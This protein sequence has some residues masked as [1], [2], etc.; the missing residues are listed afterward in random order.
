MFS[1]FEKKVTELQIRYRFLTIVAIIFVLHC[2]V[3]LLRTKKSYWIDSLQIH[4]RFVTLVAN[5]FV[6]LQQIELINVST[7]TRTPETL[8]VMNNRLFNMFVKHLRVSAW[9]FT[10]S[11][12]MFVNLC[13]CSRGFV[14]NNTASVKR[15]QFQVCKDSMDFSLNRIEIQWIQEIWWEHSISIEETVHISLEFSLNSVNYNESVEDIA[16]VQVFMCEF[17]IEFSLDGK[18]IRWLQWIQGI[19]WSSNGVFP[20]WNS[21]SV[22]SM[23]AGNLMRFQ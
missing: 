3:L 18:G 6:L 15:G 9:Y 23:N 17:W 10:H 22:T 16:S 19:W 14:F 4:Y 5:I 20:E 2:G 21:N 7:V 8:F 1:Y 13:I 11:F 12:P